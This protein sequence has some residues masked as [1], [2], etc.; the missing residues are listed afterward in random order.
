MDLRQKRF[1]INKETSKI[2]VGIFHKH[3]DVVQCKTEENLIEMEKTLRYF[4]EFYFIWD[5]L[6]CRQLEI[7]GDQMN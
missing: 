6:S 3:Q 7:I 4:F 2:Y 1:F 5:W